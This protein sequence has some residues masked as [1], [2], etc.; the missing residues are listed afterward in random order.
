MY[1][2]HSIQAYLRRQTTTELENA[3]KEI[4]LAG[5]EM[6]N[7]YGVFEILKVLKE[8]NVDIST[9]I[10]RESTPAYQIFINTVEGKIR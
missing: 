2:E 3:V 7:A 1:P 9:V 10:A 8:R 4:F 5:T 6:D